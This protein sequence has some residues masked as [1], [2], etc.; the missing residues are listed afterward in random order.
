MTYDVG[1]TRLAVGLWLALGVGACARV[2]GGEPTDTRTPAPVAAAAGDQQNGSLAD[3][4][5]PGP[6]ASRV[7]ASQTLGPRALPPGRLVR[8]TV[9]SGALAGNLLGQSASRDVIIYL[10]GGYDGEVGDTLRQD[11]YPTLY[12]FHRYDGRAEDWSNGLYQGFKIQEVVDSLMSWREMPPVI[13]V[14]PDAGGGTFGSPY[15]NSTFTGRWEDFLADELVTH[16]DDKYRT[17]RDAGSRG[18]AGHS[19]GGYAALKLAMK[20]ADVFGSVYAMSPCCLALVEEVEELGELGNIL[21]QVLGM[22]GDEETCGGS[23]PDSQ[24]PIKVVPAC[25]ENLLSLEGIAMD[26]GDED[27][28]EST[29]PWGKRFSQALTNAEVEHT[30]EVYSGAHTDRI[31]ERLLYHVMPFFARTLEAGPASRSSEP[32]F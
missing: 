29:V 9:D 32:G 3:G 21:G 18:V 26:V 31:G 14:M 24:I 7:A 17:L 10:P 25:R 1:R 8:D 5:V 20:R 6:A 12:L 13:V 16:V 28:F 15:L 19:A 4:M 22:S 2:G 30:F 23:G 27:G 11:A